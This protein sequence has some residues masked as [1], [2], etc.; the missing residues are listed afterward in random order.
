MFLSGEK[1]P[2]QP[3]VAQQ[4]Q[5]EQMHNCDSYNWANLV[6]IT[7]LVLQCTSK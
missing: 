6:S 1:T 4:S 3:L 2:A 7:M 5:E